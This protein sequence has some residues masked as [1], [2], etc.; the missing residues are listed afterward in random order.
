MLIAGTVPVEGL[1][2]TE[3]RA[4]VRGRRLIVAGK[5]I[6]VSM[7][8]AA[9]VAASVKAAE[10]LE[11]DPPRFLTAGDLGDGS[12]SL[13]LCRRLREVDEEVL[14]LHYIKP[15]IEEIRRIDVPERAVADAGGMYGAKA[16]GVS[17]R[18]HLFLPDSGELAFLADKEAH[19]P[20]YVRGF[21][22]EVDEEEAP[23]LARR[24]YEAGTVPR[25]LVVEGRLDY[26][27]EEGEVVEVVEEPLIPAMEC[28]GGTG[29]TLTGMVTALLAA[30]LDTVDA[31]TIACRANRRLGEAVGVTPA[32]R[33]S[34][35]IQAIPE[36][37]K[38][39][40]RRG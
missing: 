37:L 33:V 7:G 39:E 10:V 22:A 18:F 32:T 15:K 28:V 38:E 19:H 14:L 16:A 9:A 11:V 13:E 35:L 17:D 1:E 8:T 5:E 6:P 24:A 12:G 2:A 23:E 25:Y 21:L 31:C 27:V 30:G 40:L 34:E 20:A 3:G 4:E 29:D 26:V 36:V